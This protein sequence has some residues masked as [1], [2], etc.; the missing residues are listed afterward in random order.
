M[1]ENTP[2]AGQKVLVTGASGFIGE[3]VWRVLNQLEVEVYG[4]YHHT[5]PEE[6]SDRWRACDLT[7]HAAVVALLRDIKPDV[8]FHLASHVSGRRSIDAVMPTLRDNLVSTVNLLCVAQ[9]MAC[10]RVVLANSMEEPALSGGYPVPSSPY[11]AAKFAGAAYARM[12]HALYKTPVVIARL[13]MVYGPGQKDITKLVPHVTLSMLRGEAP[14][15]TSGSRLVDWVYVDDV[16]KGLLV[17][18]LAEGILGDTIDLGS[19]EKHTVRAVAEM[20]GQIVE[21]APPPE[22]GLL[23]ERAMEQERVADVE[24]TFKKTGW[25]PSTALRTGLQKTVE[26]YRTDYEKETVL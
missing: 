1:G 15:L 26:W 21:N 12:F 22:F 8:V 5:K 6:L 14:K 2:Y 20:I 25:K 10:K 9:E 16:V 24:T 17:L 3:H 18:G 7:D 11:A 23:A 19:G 4:T 13:F